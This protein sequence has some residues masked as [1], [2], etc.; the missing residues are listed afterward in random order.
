[1]SAID[2]LLRRFGT[3]SREDDRADRDDN[4]THRTAV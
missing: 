3:G 1:L 4:T 2:F